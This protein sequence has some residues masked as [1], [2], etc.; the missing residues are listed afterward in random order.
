[1]LALVALVAALV[2]IG[3]PAAAQTIELPGAEP[4]ESSTAAVRGTVR[5][6]G[7]S[8]EGVSITVVDA[9]GDEVDTVETD[10]DGRWEIE[11]EG[12]GDFEA[13]LDVDT[14]P[15]GAELRSEDGN[16]VEFS[17]AEGEAD[18]ILFPL[19]ESGGSSSFS[20]DRAAQLF[21]E[22]LK[23]GLVIA[24][25]AIGLSLIFGTTGLVN[26]AHG[27]MVTAGALIAW[28]INVHGGLNLIV[29]TIIT[30]V[31]CFGL[32]Y[33]I[34][35]GFWGWLRSRNTGLI[36]QLV[37]SIGLSIFFRYFYLY[38]F[39]GR[40][41]PY[42]DYSVQRGLE[43]G[44]VSIAPKDLIGIGISIAVLVGVGLVLQQTKIGKAVR[45]VADNRD[46][47][48]SSGID[49]Q[50]VIHVVWAVG[51][52]LAALGGVLLGVTEQVSFQMGQQLL[53]LMFA[54]VVLGGLGTAYG[55]LVGSLLV[56]IFVQM[57]T[58]VVSTE[59][60]NVGAL[61]ILILIL[62]V[63]PQGIMGQSERVG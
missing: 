53:L 58:L 37:I 23:F 19:G 18:T 46:L 31:I 62:L 59:L 1:M 21:V 30:M 2:A 24:L 8:L 27:E 49:V 14:L 7:E 9:D 42:N 15:E 38:L 33:L 34:D 6:E 29:A 39:G 43:L 4:G 22:G 32:G 52:S 36:A 35:K 40:T 13:V 54:G 25:A 12:G 11:L 57:S 44:P 61:L 17:L 48:E 63:R 10:E 28:F 51:F 47:A 56:G 60:K 41:R 3:G 26:F 55:A 16:I 45:A 5:F 20:F 50:R